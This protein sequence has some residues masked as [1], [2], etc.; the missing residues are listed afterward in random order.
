M[1]YQSKFF[2]QEI[3]DAVQAVR[4]NK[5]IWSSKQE[6]LVGSPGLVVGFD[7]AG[8]AISQGTQDLVGPPG[9]AGADGAPGAD[10]K[11]G[12]PGK[13]AYQIAVDNGFTG[14]ETEWLASL[15]GADGTPGA[16]G[17]PGQDGADGAP[18]ADG[19]SPTVSVTDIPG[20]HR[21][22]ITDATRP[23]TFDV[24][25]GQDGTGGGTEGVSSFNGRSG[26][27]VP[28]DDDYTAEM[29]GARPN[30]WTPTAA[31]VGARPS[32]WT[33]TAAD[34][35]ALPADTVIPAPLR[36]VTVTLT[37]SGWT[38]GTQT[39]QVAGVLADETKQ[40]IQ[41]VP[42]SSSKAAYY[43]AG[44]QCISQGAGTLTFRSEKAPT[45]D[46]AVYVAI[47]EVAAG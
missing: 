11:D 10:G 21:V 35:G 19:F 6:K 41:P 17:I 9:P 13:S 36:S 34:V 30:T 27:V 39:A 7:S 24:M 8:N 14:T 3:D 31:D 29:V 1:A 28:G 4:D 25:D 5:T 46:L 33:P 12:A 2:G 23:H 26:A 45:V 32:D 37:A 15:K 42:A 38:D 20:G 47:Q 18:G 16:P 44:I 22:T 43:D 40:L